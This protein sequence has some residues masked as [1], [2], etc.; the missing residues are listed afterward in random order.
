MGRPVLE[1][2]FTTDPPLHEFAYQVDRFANEIE[3]L[4]PL[5]ELFG[6]VFRSEMTQQFATEG[7]HGSGGWAA[8]S[9]AYEEWKREHFPGRPIG[10][11]TG[12][13][14]SSMTGGDGYSEHIGEM[15]ADFGMDESSAAVPYGKYFD[16][17]RPV[18]R[19][20]ESAV[21]SWRRACQEWLVAATRRHPIGKPP[22]G[23]L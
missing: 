16:V 19:M 18:I 7:R 1:V 10:V 15:T 14:R 8:L 3:D 23:G 5:M 20:P 6:D 17:R 2:S 21:A 12:A 13:L 22:V 11:L 4:R 9:P